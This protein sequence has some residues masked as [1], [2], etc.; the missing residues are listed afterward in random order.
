MSTSIPNTENTPSVLD[1]ARMCETMDWYYAYSDDG[2]V[3]RTGKE[4]EIRL[5]K[6]AAAAGPL[7]VRILLAWDEYVADVSRGNKGTAVRPT[8]AQAWTLPF[9]ST[10]SLRCSG[11]AAY[12]PLSRGYVFFLVSFIRIEVVVR[13]VE[14]YVHSVFHI[15]S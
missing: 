7:A 6:L 8:R 11:E 15:P 13:I 1:I 14:F 10:S 2:D 9:P 4:A 12:P 5:R 3:Y